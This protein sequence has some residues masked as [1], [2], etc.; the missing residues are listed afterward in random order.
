MPAA[1][2]LLTGENGLRCMVSP[3]LH[4]IHC[5][6]DTHAHLSHK[7]EVLYTLLWTAAT[8]FAPVYAVLRYRLLLQRFKQT[9][10]VC[11][12]LRCYAALHCMMLEDGLKG[13]VLLHV[14]FL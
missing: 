3:W 7:A 10:K 11:N 1:F 2:V 4:T 5:V 6:V 12:A 8:T 9:G 13:Y 14:Q